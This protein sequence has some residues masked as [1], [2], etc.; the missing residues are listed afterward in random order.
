MSASLR[1]PTP[2]TITDAHD[3][4]VQDAVN[5]SILIVDDDPRIQ[6]SLAEAQENRTTNVRTAE[7]APSLLTDSPADVVLTDVRMPG[8]GGL[9]LLNLLKERSPHTAVILMTAYQDLPTVATA[10]RT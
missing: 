5:R 8:I 4:S 10:M 3:L 9:E 1:L 6:T 2:P 7:H